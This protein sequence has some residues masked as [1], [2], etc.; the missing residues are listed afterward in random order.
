MSRIG[1]MPVLIPADVEVTVDGQLV[2]VLGPGELTVALR[3]SAHKF[4]A[5]ALDKI[6][7]AGGAATEL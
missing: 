1:R 4:S 5:S 3:V 2:K 7:A 6:A